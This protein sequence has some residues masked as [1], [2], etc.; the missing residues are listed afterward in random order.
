MS[1]KRRREGVFRQQVSEK[2][3]NP[4]RDIEGI[5]RHAGAEQVGEDLLPYQPE[6]AADGSPDREQPDTPGKSARHCG[7]YSE[8][9]KEGQ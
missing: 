6:Q 1:S 9:R 7:Y 3:G 8:N 2:V 4:E 5:G